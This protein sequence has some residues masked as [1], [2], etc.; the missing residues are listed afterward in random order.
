[1]PGVYQ[2]RRRVLIQG[3]EANARIYKIPEIGHMSS[4][5]FYDTR[6]L[7]QA[8]RTRR[9]ARNLRKPKQRRRLFECARVIEEAWLGT[10]PVELRPQ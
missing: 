7:H 1:M 8:E 5:V 10:P 9:V 3:G 6:L 2:V 4:V